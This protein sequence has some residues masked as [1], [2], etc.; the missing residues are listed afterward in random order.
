M[1]FKRGVLIGFG[2][3]YV[4]GAKAGRERYEQIRDM[5][6]RFNGTERV[7]QLTDKGKELAGEAS[8]KSLYAVQHGVQKATTAVKDRLGN[9]D[10]LESGDT[11][12][13]TV[14]TAGI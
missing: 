6:D 10:D 8:R 5:W 12:S 4:L 3:G 1:G 14:G 9:E 11:G 7:Q 2:A 13:P